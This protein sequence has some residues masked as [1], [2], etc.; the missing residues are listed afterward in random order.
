MALTYTQKKLLVFFKNRLF[1]DVIAWVVLYGLIIGVLMIDLW[2][3][4]EGIVDDFGN[5]MSFTD[6]VTEHTNKNEAG[7]WFEAFQI[8]LRDSFLILLGLMSV[9]YFNLRFLKQRLLNKYLTKWQL[10]CYY[11]VLNYGI[12]L[13]TD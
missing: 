11:F 13:G 4:S 1:T 2:R 5:P 10:F 6:F 3:K 12:G 7:G 8:I 9:A